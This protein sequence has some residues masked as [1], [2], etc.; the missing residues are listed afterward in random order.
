MKYTYQISQFLNKKVNLTSL[1]LSIRSS[2]IT[3]ALDYS[4]TNETECDIFFKSTLNETEIGILLSI[5]NKH[6][7]TPLPYIELPQRVKIVEESS[8]GVYKTGGHYQAITLILDI[9]GSTGLYTKDISFPFPIGI[10]SASWFCNTENLG[11]IASFIIAPDRIIGII[12]SAVTSG[13]TYIYVSPT[14]IQYLKIGYSVKINNENL[15]R[16]YEVDSI[17]NR[18]KTEYKPINN[19]SINTPTYIKM[20]INI[21]EYFYFS[22]IGQGKIGDGKIGAEIIPS[23]TVLRIEYNNNNGRQKVFSIFMDMYY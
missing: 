15:G 18:I 7:G 4:I 3:V 8:D 16:A 20:S 23:N 11:D 17:N 2:M 12:T 6:E 14:V 10:F 5:V 1:E 9:S 19:Y 21:V 22:G 13:D